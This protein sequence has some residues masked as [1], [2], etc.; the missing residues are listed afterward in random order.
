MVWR[1]VSGNSRPKRGCGHGPGEKQGHLKRPHVQ[2]LSR[3]HHFSH[4]RFILDVVS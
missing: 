3:D 4:I 2:N 1:P